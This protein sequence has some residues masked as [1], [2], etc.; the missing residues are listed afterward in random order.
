MPTIYVDGRPH[1]VPE[2]GRNL[3]DACLSL[4]FDIPYFCWHPA[5][6]SAGAC[7]QCAIKV[8][9]TADDSRGRIVMAC[10]TPVTDGVRLSIDDPEA[11]AFRASV[12]EWL[13][14]GH[15]HDCPVCDEGGEC[16]L[17]DMTVMTGHAYRR[18]RF[19]KRTHRNQDLGP[20]VNHEMN[21]CIQCYRCVRFYQELAGGRDLDVLGW[22]DHVY[23]GRHEDG[24]LESPFAGNLTEVCPTGVFTDKTLKPHY[25]RPWDLQTSPSVCVHCGLGCNTLPGERYGVLR[26]IRNRFNAH[27]NGFFLCDRGRYGHQFVNRE[28][29]LREPLLREAN[30]RVRPASP[31]EAL[32]RLRFI[33]R[34]GAAVGIG[35][36]RASMET[37]FALRELVGADAF[38]D[39][40]SQR[41]HEL[42]ATIRTVLLQGPG[43]SASVQDVAR[44]DAVL[45]LGED[46]Q[47]TAPLLAL[48]L[49]QA[50]FQQAL[51]IAQRLN[52]HKYLDSAVREAIQQDTGPLFIATPDETPIDDAATATYRRAP[53]DIARLGLAVAHR[54]DP[55]ASAPEL[56]D[57]STDRLAQEI[58]EALR[59]A[60]RPLVVCGH[61]CGSTAVI[62]AA[63]NVVCALEAAG[64]AG[65]L[66]CSVPECNSM[67]LALMDG[68]G[69]A[70]A[71]QAL[72]SGR[73]SV[74]IVAEN[75][76]FRRMGAEAAE[77]LLAR[78]EHVI[79][80][81]SLPTRTTERASVVLPAA[82]FAECSGTLVNAEGRGQRFI[83]TFV[84]EGQVQ[85]SWRWLG[86]MLAARDG[87]GAPPW[88]N[89][90]EILGALAGEL[91]VCG[92]IRNLAPPASYRLHGQRVPRRSHRFS[93]QTAIHAHEDVREPDPP[94]DPDSPMSFSMEGYHGQPPSPLIAR[95]RAPG[96]NSVQSV[97]KFSRGVAGPLQGGDPG[98]RLIEPER[99]HSLCYAAA[100]P[101]F[102]PQPGRWLAVPAHHVFGSEELSAGSPSVAALA[103]P[104]SLGV[105]PADAETMQL[106]EGQELGLS[107]ERE[108]RSLPVRLRP[109]LPRGVVTVP[110]GLPGLEGLDL[111]AWVTLIV[112]GLPH[113]GPRSRHADA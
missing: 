81:D 99:E 74:L 8:F 107:L 37:N 51:G 61:G 84:P 34:T 77:A 102:E 79:V 29:R 60:E 41:D 42:M 94:D 62:E 108:V 12:I 71:E 98:R 83:Q 86:R 88:A 64:K 36:P 40:L 90:D 109:Q 22:H 110:V 80:L 18:H 15:P 6:H 26:R 13:M 96:W 97:T 46:V 55:E 44:A 25:T 33:L 20:L 76:L 21:R 27:V 66:S 5:M 56:L 9:A 75:D 49:R 95:F 57:P 72:R 112:P 43:R 50:V 65:S 16:H 68:R 45:I 93:G 92:G 113:R 23:F 11:V 63:T 1:E 53:D 87:L 101:P 14:V 69:L 4:G 106:E 52:I 7:R 47:N 67:G 54:L 10:M 59:T 78:A 58:A 2:E 70:A 103:P 3:L 85:A 39:G 28:D 111:P 73:A 82:T 31:E 91:P 24:V 19:P 100:V 89:L 104:P 38:H 35:S 105:S 32:E 48:A 17:Q 30:G